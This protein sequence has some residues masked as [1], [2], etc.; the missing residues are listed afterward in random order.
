MYFLRGILPWQNMKGNTAKVKYEMI[1]N[2]KISTPLDEL[3]KGHPSQLAEFI[4]YARDLRFD[5]NP[6]Y[7][8]LKDLLEKAATEHNIDFTKKYS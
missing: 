3:C 8:Y 4:R 7:N 1:M 2:K 6:D 5:E